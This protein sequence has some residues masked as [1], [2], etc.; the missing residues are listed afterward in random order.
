[1][2]T[3]RPQ[4]NKVIRRFDGKETGAAHL[5]AYRIL[6]KRYCR[7]HSC[8]QLDHILSGG[9]SRVN[10]FEVADH[11]Q[12]QY[13]FMLFQQPLQR[14]DANPD[15]VG[16]K[17]WM[18]IN[19]RCS[20]LIIRM[21]LRHFTQHKASGLPAADDLAAFPVGISFPRDLDHKRCA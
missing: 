7:P 11:G 18:D 8:F 19:I 10:S 5:Y 4:D 3:V 16:I 15:I 17:E 20:F 14:A 1:M 12:R 21:H 9:I 13:A 2:E 6:E